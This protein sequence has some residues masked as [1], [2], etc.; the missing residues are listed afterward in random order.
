MLEIQERQK[1]NVTILDLE[2]NVIMGG[3]SAR[4]REAISRLIKENKTEILLNF[5]KVRYIDSSGAGELL[6]GFGSL[7]EI[8]GKLKLVSLTPKVREVLKL[9]SILPI[10]DVYDD[11]T[12]AL[13]N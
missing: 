12:S 4:L 3:G 13:N 11:E 9:S 10:L 2:G 1:G 8:G 7:N 5:E 6:S